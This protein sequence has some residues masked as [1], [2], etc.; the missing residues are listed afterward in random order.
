VGR[1][2]ILSQWCEI[3]RGVQPHL[4]PLDALPEKLHHVFTLTVCAF[5]AFG[6]VHKD[7]LKNRKG[8]FWLHYDHLELDDMAKI[9]AINYVNLCNNAK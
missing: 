5:E 7:T 9:F 6:P 4:F 8:T 2:Y 1:C 3:R